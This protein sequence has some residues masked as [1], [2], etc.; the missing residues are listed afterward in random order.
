M[1]RK[2]PIMYESL[3]EEIMLVGIPIAMW[4]DQVSIDICKKRDWKR[5]ILETE[6]GGLL[7]R[8]STSL[9]TNGHAS[10][11]KYTTNKLR[12]TKYPNIS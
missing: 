11:S 10:T 7:V 5:T 6:R 8:L 3:L 12:R 4:K 1:Q 9:G 2:S